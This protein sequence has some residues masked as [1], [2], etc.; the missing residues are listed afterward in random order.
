MTKNC[1]NDQKFWPCFDKGNDDTLCKWR[2]SF[3][4]EKIYQFLVLFLIIFFSHFRIFLI[5]RFSYSIF[6]NR[7]FLYFFFS[8]SFCDSGFLWYNFFWYL[9]LCAWFFNVFFFLILSFLLEIIMVFPFHVTIFMSQ[10]FAV[11]VQFTPLH[12][13]RK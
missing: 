13:I 4:F 9:N 2:K 7:I 10:F 1:F 6:F 5:P 11:T 8:C 3:P 12:W